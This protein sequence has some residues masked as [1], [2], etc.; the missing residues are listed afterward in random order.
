MA[1]RLIRSMV[2]LAFVAAAAAG[3][4]GA[5]NDPGWHTPPE[6]GS[7]QLAD[8]GWHFATE[9]VAAPPADPGWHVVTET[10]A[11][12]PADPGWS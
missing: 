12:Q 8:P 10:I 3:I 1:K 2:A 11:A 4:A 7:V 6:N 5:A 9:T